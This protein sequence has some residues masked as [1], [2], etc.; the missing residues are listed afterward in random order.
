LANELEKI[1]LG[2]G[3]KPRPTYISAKIEEEY[4]KEL[5]T[6]LK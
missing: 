3:R 1:D 2:D 6:L 4:N 5:I